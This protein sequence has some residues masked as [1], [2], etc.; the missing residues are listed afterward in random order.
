MQLGGKSNQ[1]YTVLKRTGIDELDP[2]TPYLTFLVAPFSVRVLQSFINIF[3]RDSYAILSSSPETLGQLEDL[4]LVHL[5]K[6]INKQM[7]KTLLHYITK[8]AKIKIKSLLIT[9]SLECFK[10]EDAQKTKSSY[11]THSLESL[12]NS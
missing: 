11:Y 2:K 12:A 5:L 3:P 4:L 1:T 7:P 10:T 9:H 8:M 6:F